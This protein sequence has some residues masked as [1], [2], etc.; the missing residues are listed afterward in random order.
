MDFL[1][2]TK[3]E[4]LMNQAITKVQAGSASVIALTG[5]FSTKN[6]INQ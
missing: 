3:I 1:N 4:A 2:F 6:T 5:K